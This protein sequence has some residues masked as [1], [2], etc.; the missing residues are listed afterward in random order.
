MNKSHKYIYLYVRYACML[1]VILLIFLFLKYAF[2]ILTYSIFD[3]PGFIILPIT[4]FPALMILPGII[5]EDYEYGFL[6]FSSS[7][8]KYDM[9]LGLTFGLGPIYLFFRDHDKK[10]KEYY[11]DK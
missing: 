3:M 8:I 2:G 4:I 11:K 9:F 5:F 6:G 1:H 7:K 10:L